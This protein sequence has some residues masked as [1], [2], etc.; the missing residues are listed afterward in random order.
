ML[1]VLSEKYSLIVT[2]EENQLIGGYGQ[3]V[4]AFLHKMYARISF[5]LWVFPIILWVMPL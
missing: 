2:V 4:S 3:M 1:H 5:L